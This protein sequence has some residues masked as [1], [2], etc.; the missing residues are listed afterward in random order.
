MGMS[1]TQA[2]Y[3]SLVAQQTNLEYQGQQINQERSILSQQVS[4]LYNTLLSLQVP[5]PPS[6]QDFT[7]I[8]YQGS[9]GATNY[10]FDATNIKPGDNDTYIVT[11][12]T[13]QYGDAIQEA[14]G[15]STAQARSDIKASQV[16]SVNT[17]TTYTVGSSQPTGTPTGPFAEYVAG[18]PAQ[19]D[20]SYYVAD[21]A[22]NLVEYDPAVHT[23]ISAYY[24]LHNDP[25]NYDPNNNNYWDVTTSTS[26]SPV[27]ITPAELAELYVLENG[28][29]RPAT[30]NDVTQNG[31]NYTLDP[32]VTYYEED[33]AG[34][35]MSLANSEYTI[36]GHPVMTLDEAKNAGIIT[37][38]QFDSYVNAISHSSMYDTQNLQYDKDDFYIY[39]NDDNQACFVLIDE[40]E[41][42]SSDQT[43]QVSVYNYISNGQYTS[44]VQHTDCTLTFDPSSGRIM[45]IDIP[46]RDQNGNIIGYSKMN[47]SA[48]TVTDTLA[49]DEAMAQYEY[50]Q[51]EYDVEQQKINARTELIQR[52]DR[53]LELKLTR[54]DTQRKQIT[55]ELEALQK[56]LDKNIETTYKTFSG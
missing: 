3:L 49:Y 23:N 11:L 41:R 48:N 13:S 5:T 7:K 2:R 6:T 36:A 28:E 30:S 37:P 22:G 56:V 51:Y 27:T 40:V 19:D 50:A 8:V 39:F 32:T 33:S 9:I 10:Q 35:E 24:I 25:S 54:L 1:A 47:L 42:R 20:P 18:T 12:K 46:K 4:D 26:T 44:N 29:L 52:M 34:S 38:D 55:T 53:D 14:M 16:P 43:G 17:T 15:T 31:N 45:S 21:Q